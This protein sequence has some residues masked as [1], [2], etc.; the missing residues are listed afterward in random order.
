MKMEYQLLTDV[1]AKP[2]IAKAG[3]FDVFTNEKF[4]VI[5]AI[6]G[7]IKVDWS[8]VLFQR[9]MAMISLERQ[10]FGFAISSVVYLKMLVF[11]PVNHLYS[12]SSRT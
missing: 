5:A 11:L 4:L 10:S 7:E 1:V 8:S 3:S 2:I 6:A 12:I 9:L